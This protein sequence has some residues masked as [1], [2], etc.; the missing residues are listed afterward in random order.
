MA[1][2]DRLMTSAQ[3]GG[4]L[5][6]YSSNGW[7]YTTQDSD[8]LAPVETRWDGYPGFTFPAWSLVDACVHNGEL[9]VVWVEP[10]WNGSDRVMRGP[11]VRKW[12]GGSWVSLGG[13]VEPSLAAVS[14][15]WPFTRSNWETTNVTD[16]IGQKS[17]P[18]RPRIVSDGTN[19]FVA[20]LVREVEV[21]PEYPAVGSWVY[22]TALAAR[23]SGTDYQRWSP[24]KLYLRKWNAGGGTW[25]L[26]GHIPAIS[27]NVC[28]TSDAGFGFGSYILPGR[29][30]EIG[31]DAV[32]DG[33]GVVYAAF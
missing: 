15:T 32:P 25:D 2:Y 5:Q 7:P 9:H 22:G 26:Y 33:S 3:L 23:T 14:L 8:D 30:S 16:A 31:L 19:L 21:A 20:Y 24:R 4:G 29:V 1:L 10:Q 17:A 27:N 13:E 12:N 6:T 18:S 11:F 28:S